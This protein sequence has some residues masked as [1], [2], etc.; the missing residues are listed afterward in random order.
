MLSC[1]EIARENVRNFLKDNK[2]TFGKIDA[3][4]RKKLGINAAS[5]APEVPA[6]P[7]NG[8]ATATEAVKSRRS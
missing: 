4:L 2:D 5:G 6:V 8:A 7:V 3:E 1:A